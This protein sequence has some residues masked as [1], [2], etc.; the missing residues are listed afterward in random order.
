MD[1]HISSELPARRESFG[2]RRVT[3]RLALNYGARGRGCTSLPGHRGQQRLSRLAA[4]HGIR[5]GVRVSLKCVPRLAIL[6]GDAG[7]LL[8]DVRRLVSDKMKTWL[9]GKCDVIAVGVRLSTELTVGVCRFRADVCLHVRDVMRTEQ[10]LYRIEMRQPFTGSRD[11]ALSDRR[12]I[13]PRGL[14][15]FRTSDA[16]LSDRSRIRRSLNPVP[17]VR[18]IGQQ[19]LGL[20]DKR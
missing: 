19:R 18:C 15:R 7:A 9:L 1:L 12:R 16:A 6:E 10:P 8:D 4:N 17:A 3:G 13:S 14:L 5:Y 20:I 2:L 11:A